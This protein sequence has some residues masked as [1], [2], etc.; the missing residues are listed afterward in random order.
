MKTL[1]FLLQNIGKYELVGSANR[2]VEAITFDSRK[3]N[4]SNT[5]FV[6]QRGTHVDGHSFI[7]KVIEQGGRMVLCEELPE[8]I[9]EQVTF[10]KVPN[11]DIALGLLASAFYDFPSQKLHLVGITGT[12]GKTTTVTLLYRLFNGMG[13]PKTAL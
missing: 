9:D 10:I 4:D 1:S 2:Q 13:Y 3:V 5:L 8:H 7:G 11:S 12:N 6:A